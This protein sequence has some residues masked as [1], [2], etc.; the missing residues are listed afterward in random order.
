MSK[1]FKDLFGGVDALEPRT[2]PAIPAPLVDLLPWR[3]WDEAGE[4]YVNEGGLGFVLEL[5][6]FAGVDEG[7]L[8]ALAGTLA[9]SAPE[10]SVVQV[11]HWTSPRYGGRLSS[12]QDRG[13]RRAASWR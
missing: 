8:D 9:D 1:R 11:I 13:R 2:L 6:P 4:F 12:G 10:R 3:A 7:T 5:P